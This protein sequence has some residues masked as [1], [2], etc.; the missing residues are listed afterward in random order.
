MQ[1][2]PLDQVLAHQVGIVSCLCSSVTYKC[3]WS[4][5]VFPSQRLLACNRD[6]GESLHAHSYSSVAVHGVCVVLALM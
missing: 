5:K 6:V 4:S 1:R 2:I 3:Q